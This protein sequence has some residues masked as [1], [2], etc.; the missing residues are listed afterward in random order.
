MKPLAKT[1]THTLAALGL[2]GA[3]ASPAF[4]GPAY[5]GKI[6][7]MTISVPTNDLDLGT[8]AGQRTLDQR[9]EKAVRSVCRTTSVTTGSRVMS[10]EAK[11]C[12]A[13][14]RIDAK[15]QVAVLLSNEQRGG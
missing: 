2:A 13:K 10:Q 14:A 3:V 4:A 6:Q 5:D 8:A 12:L 15:R 7:R 1:I 11:A 9:V